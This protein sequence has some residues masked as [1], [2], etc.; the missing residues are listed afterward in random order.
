M[1][2]E[3]FKIP[4]VNISFHSYGLMLVIGL[5]LGMELAKFLA[6]RSGMNPDFFANAA[7]LGLISGLIGARIAYVLQFSEE[8]TRGTT[9]ENIWN[10]V[11]LT[12]G[13]LVYYGGFL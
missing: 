11:N 9:S 10:A 7:V 12:S 3:L 5:L 2:P 13:G 4:F 1:F 8:F 6:R